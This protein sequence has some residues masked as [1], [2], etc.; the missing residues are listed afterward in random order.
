MDWILW[1]D[2]SNAILKRKDIRNRIVASAQQWW[3]K[4]TD[5]TTEL[6]R[7]NGVINTEEIMQVVREL[8]CEYYGIGMWELARND[9]EFLLNKYWIPEDKFNI[10]REWDVALAYSEFA[11]H[12][13]GDGKQWEVASSPLPTTTTVVDAPEKN[14]KQEEQKMYMTAK[15]NLQQMMEG[16]TD[17]EKLELYEAQMKVLDLKLKNANAW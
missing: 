15:Q 17:K 12:N 11:K 8:I 4:P 14:V 3:I 10:L 16:E 1:T 2:S 6:L 9:K 13:N 7:S 5:I